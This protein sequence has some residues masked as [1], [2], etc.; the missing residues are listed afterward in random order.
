MNTDLR[1]KLHQL[2]NDNKIPDPKLSY[3]LQNIIREYEVQHAGMR[4]SVALQQLFDETLE[5]IKSNL[6]KNIRIQTGFGSL[7]HITGG[8]YPGEFIVIGGRPAM[9]KTQLLVNMALNISKTHPILYFSFDLSPFLLGSRFVSAL[10]QIGV[11]RI[12][13]DN[14]KKKEEK[15]LINAREALGEHKILVNDSGSN[16]LTAMKSHIVSCREK[17]DIK[18]VMIDYLQL[19]SSSRSKY[20]RDQEVSAICRELKKLARDLGLVIIVTSQLSRAVDQRGGT[21]RPQLA[22]LRESGS[23]EQDA[24]KVLLIYRMEYYGFYEDEDGISTE[25]ITELIVAKNRNGGLGAARLITDEEF[26]LFADYSDRTETFNIKEKRLGDLL[27]S[28]F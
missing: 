16:S 3:I 22:D 21:R 7:D 17:N 5:T 8:M 23:I 12:L 25:G 26:T 15:K 14:I 20:N 18:V 27:D 4:E 24:D 13:S 11:G 9:G 6:S 19:M 1:E 10:S 28:P 2:L